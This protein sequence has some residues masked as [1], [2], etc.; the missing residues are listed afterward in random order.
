MLAANII[1]IDR[2]SLLPS[3]SSALPSSSHPMPAIAPASPLSPTGR[4]VTVIYFDKFKKVP[5]L[6]QIVIPRGLYGTPMTALSE[7]L[8]NTAPAQSASRPEILS[9]SPTMGMLVIDDPSDRRNDALWLS[10]NSAETN[11]RWFFRGDAIVFKTPAAEED[12]SSTRLIDCSETD[13][14]QIRSTFLADFEQ[15]RKHR[16]ELTRMFGNR[17]IVLPWNASINAAAAAD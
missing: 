4:K 13:L 1:N 14:L 5:E 15:R 7:Q 2:M 6:R 10:S 3:S 11:E 9:I 12:G 17:C 16:E 8:R